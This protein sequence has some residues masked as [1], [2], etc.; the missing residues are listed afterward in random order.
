MIRTKSGLLSL[1]AFVPVSFCPSGLLYQWAFVLHPMGG[2]CPIG[3]CPSG[4]LSQWAFVLRPAYGD[5]TIKVGQMVIIVLEK[6]KVKHIV[7]T[8]E[9]A[10]CNPFLFFPIFSLTL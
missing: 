3:F 9:N 7:E 5:D 1:W 4:L 8:G 6:K 2:F 10:Y